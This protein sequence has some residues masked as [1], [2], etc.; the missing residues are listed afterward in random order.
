MG[1]TATAGDA[2]VALS[3]STSSGATSYS[4]KRATVS[5]GP[6]TLVAG[7]LTATTFTDTPVTNGTP[8]FYVVS[9][10][11]AAGESPNSTQVTATPTAP[12]TA[13]AAP[14]NLTATTVSRT[15]INL[16]WTDNANNETGFLIERSTNGTSFTQIATAGANVTTFA[17]TG[18]TANKR[19]Y[20]RVRATN[21]VGQSVYSNVA[22]ARTLK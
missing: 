4:V 13:P 10:S 1:L 15:Q 22:N 3:W 18:L 8:Y 12:P 5:G 21:A 2:Q 17:S 11:N 6:Y 16:A 20:Y 14:T 7:G 9:A 19:Y